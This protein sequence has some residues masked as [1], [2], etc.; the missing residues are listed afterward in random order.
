MTGNNSFA[1]AFAAGSM[2]VPNP[3]AGM[4]AL[5]TIREELSALQLGI[6]EGFEFGRRKIDVAKDFPQRPGLE[7]LIAVYRHRRL[8]AAGR[9][10]VMRA[11]NADDRETSPLEELHHLAPRDARHLTHAP[12][13]PS[14]VPPVERPAD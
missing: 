11:A 2:R 6:E 10:H 9:H 12:T 4:T 7:R 1:T 3:A 14:R 8:N 5:V 13:P